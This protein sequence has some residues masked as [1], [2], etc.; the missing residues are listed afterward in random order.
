MQLLPFVLIDLLYS[1]DLE[2]YNLS[3]EVL[4][5]KP[6]SMV[7]DYEINGKVIVLPIMGKGKFKF[8]A[9]KVDFFFK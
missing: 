5:P 3:L 8:D 7:G 6:V 4:L 9:G 1:Y 2:T